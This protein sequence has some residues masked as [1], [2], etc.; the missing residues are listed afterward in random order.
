[1]HVK[2]G[3][4]VVVI[5]GKDKGKKGKV[6]QAFP[7]KDRVIVEGVNMVTKHQKPS[8]K[9]QQGGIVHQEAPIHIS[10]VML[11]DAKAKSGTRVKHEIQNGKKVRVSVKT[12]EL[13]N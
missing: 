10:N 8:P 9:L 4:T 1:M 13:F 2:K 11:F 6:L 12:G 5:A 3:D 7:T